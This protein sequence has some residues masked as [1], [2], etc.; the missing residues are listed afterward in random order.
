MREPSDSARPGRQA[1]PG[2]AGRSRRDSGA[3]DLAVRLFDMALDPRRIRDALGA[4][5]EDLGAHCVWLTALPG[6]L[7]TQLLLGCSGI[8]RKAVRR[9]ED[10]H[11]WSAMLLGSS[12]KRIASGQVLPYRDTVGARQLRQF[13][14]F[15]TILQPLNCGDGA[16]LVVEQSPAFTALLHVAGRRDPGR[17]WNRRRLERLSPL[18]LRAAQAALARASVDQLQ[19]T[20]TALLG[21]VDM[22]VAI[23][24]GGGRVVLRNARAAELQRGDGAAVVDGRLRLDAAQDRRSLE[25]ALDSLL[26]GDESGIGDAYEMLAKGGTGERRL[27]LILARID[28]EPVLP[29]L[30]PSVLVL[31]QDLDTRPQI[32]VDR[33]ASLFDL[34]RGEARVAGLL[35]EGRSLQE[36]AAYLSRSPATIRNQLHRVFTKTGVSSQAQLI[37]LILR[38][39]PMVRFGRL[40]PWIPPP[41]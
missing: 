23:I 25:A 7:R 1:A 22:P 18:L 13:D 15:R 38:L 39:T 34:T 17:P 40:T 28:A 19:R 10:D 26:H 3:T 36:C 35:A 24:D 11:G 20:V 14:G 4:I 16:A 27:R 2:S 29:G 9:L 8:D 21:K 31:M 12:R 33:L 32:P 30:P 6:A 37:A 5:A 41:D